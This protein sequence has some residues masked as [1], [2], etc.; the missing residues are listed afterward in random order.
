[1]HSAHWAD[2][3]RVYFQYNQPNWGW[4][5]IGDPLGADHMNR[6]FLG[7]AHV[8]ETGSGG[9]T[10][11][12]NC[13]Y[14]EDAGFHDEGECGQG[15][16]NCSDGTS[17]CGCDGV[18]GDTLET[19]AVEDCNG[20]CD[21]GAVVICNSVADGGGEFCAPAGT[22][23]CSDYTA[24]DCEENPEDSSCPGICSDSQYPYHLDLAPLK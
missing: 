18:C 20:L 11:E 24:E 2:D 1:M 5:E 7:Y 14:D 21:G 16:Y 23:V 6:V 17:G 8:E 22:A 19:P 13:S 4:N 3:E 9:C 15:L 12:N 10:D